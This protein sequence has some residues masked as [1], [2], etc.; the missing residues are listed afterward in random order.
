MSDISYGE[1]IKALR[2][3]KGLTIEQLAG[4]TGLSI[5]MISQMERDNRKITQT[6]FDKILEIFD[7]L[8]HQFFLSSVIDVPVIHTKSIPVI[9]WVH[10]GAFA[11]AVDSWPVGVSGIADPVQ[12]YVKTG[13]NAFALIVEG[14][15]MFP[16]F[17]PGDI[18][19]V[20]PAIRCDNGSVCV[21][22]VNGEVSMK[23]FWDK[24]NEIILKP[25]NDKYPDTIIKKDSKVDFRVIGKVVDIRSKL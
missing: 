13:P 11:D 6:S 5:S 17:F 23:L 9:S 8:P 2:L 10:A 19:I 21:V 1:R 12:S 4:K 20:D 3:A 18:A 25:M 22:W 24:E 7:I 15:S 14:D 16:R